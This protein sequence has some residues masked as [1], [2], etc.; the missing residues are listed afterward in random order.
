MPSNGVSD[1]AQIPANTPVL[2]GVAAIQQKFERHTEGLE[3]IELMLE[4]LRRAAAD[5]GAPNLL[6]M[7]D[8]IMVPKGIWEYSDPGRL[9]AQALAG[10]RTKVGPARTVLAEIGILQQTLMTR[11]CQ[12]IRD[13]QADVVFVVGAEA[14]HRSLLAQKAGQVASETVQAGVVPDVMLH[15]EDEIWS[16][17]E[18]AAGL[19]MPVGFYAIIDS[20]LRYKRGETVAQQCDQMARMYAKFSAVAAANAD[21]WSAEVVAEDHIRVQSASNRMLAFPYTK[22]HNSQWNVDQGAGLILCSARVARELGI[23]P[24]QWVFPRASTESNFMSTVS[25]RKDLG[26]CLGFRFAGHTA[27]KLAGVDFADLRLRELYSCFPAA[28]RSQ[29]EEFGMGDEGGLTVTGG[30]TFGGGPL[31]NFVLQA[32]VKMAQLLRA[33]PTEVGLVTSVSGMLTK[34]AC[35][36]WSASPGEDGWAFADVTDQVRRNTQLCELVEHYDGKAAVAGYTV[37]YQGDAPWRGVAVFDLPDGKRTVA[38]TEDPVLIGR[39]M[40]DEQCGKLLMLADG[41]FS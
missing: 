21:A 35:A 1:H 6:G 31:N 28:V 23:A 2:V 41:Q 8:E 14:K 10:E 19:A 38:Y 9:I 32:T 30:M 26:G 13:G 15:P 18:S 16:P 11:A 4:A 5:A 39:L 17:I 25:S 27:A 29:L 36:L 40:T 20:A 24:S 34:Q 33:A 3:A 7:V 22:L 12:R 37:L